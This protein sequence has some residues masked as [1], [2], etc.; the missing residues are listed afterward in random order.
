[1][2]NDIADQILEMPDAPLI[3]QRVQ[4]SLAAEQEIRK[5][6]YEAVSEDQKVEF[7][8][9]EIIIHPPV[10]KQHDNASGNLYILLKTFTAK[11]QLGYVAHEKVMVSLTRNDYEPD[12]CFFQK[13]IAKDFTEDQTLFPAPNFIAEVVSPGTKKRDYGIKYDDYQAHGI[14]E[15]WIIS[16]KQQ[17]IEKYVLDG[18]KYELVGT[19]DRQHSIE[20]EA[21]EGFSIP[22][23]AIF[24]EKIFLQT[25]AELL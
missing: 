6:F 7:I 21:V 19:Y 14:K 4:E 17:V 16:P 13:A 25:L 3:L 5:H 10:K 15:Y 18:E 2:K 1:M 9:G 20:S 24:D 23:K 22:V 11:H 12:V 8:N